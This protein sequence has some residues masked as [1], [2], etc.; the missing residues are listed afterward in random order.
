M[1]A[2]AAAATIGGRDVV[3]MKPGAF[4]RMKST[5]SASPVM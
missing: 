5:T 3:K 1:L 2:R 4:E